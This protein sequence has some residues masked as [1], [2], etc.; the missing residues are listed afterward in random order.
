MVIVY[1]SGG[2][3]RER[4]FYNGEKYSKIALQNKLVQDYPSAN[5]QFKK[6][7]DTLYLVY[8]DE[9]DGPSA[10]LPLPSQFQK[11]Q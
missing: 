11:M 1:F 3:T 7:K 10:V 4:Q 9:S 8:P 2:D 5:L 6:N